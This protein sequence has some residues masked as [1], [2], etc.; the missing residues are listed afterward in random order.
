ML[1]R[2]GEFVASGK[3]EHAVPEAAEILRVW[4][5]TLNLLRARDVEGLAARCDN[6]MKFLLLNK[7]RESYG[8]SWQSAELKALDLRYG[9][10]DP[11]EGLF[12]QMA[13]GGCVAEM[14]SDAQIERAV[15]EPPEDTRAY[16]RAQILRRWGPAVAAMDWSWIDFRL[17]AARGWW[18]VARLPMADPRRH[19]RDEVDAIL[20]ECEDVEDLLAALAQ[21]AAED[22]GD[23]R[24]SMNGAAHASRKR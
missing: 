15:E 2:A 3:V 20:A 14:P 9:S 4:Q 1:E 23:E 13:E 16:L 19:T 12:F 6:W 24:A 21:D 11:S 10:L 5:E 18:S 7:R 22:R 8:R 17:Q